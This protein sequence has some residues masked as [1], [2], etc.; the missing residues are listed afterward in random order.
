MGPILIMLR[1]SVTWISGPNMHASA[2][3]PD[4]K[5]QIIG[6][7]MHGYPS[8]CSNSLS[9]NNLKTKPD[10]LLIL[11]L[12]SHASMV[13]MLKWIHKLLVLKFKLRVLIWVQRME[14]RT[15]IMLATGPNMGANRLHGS[16]SL[17]IDFIAYSGPLKA[18]TEKYSHFALCSK[19]KHHLYAEIQ[20]SGSFASNI[21]KLSIF[22]CLKIL[23]LWV[24]SQNEATSW[25]GR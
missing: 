12:K 4:L 1:S 14:L 15:I 23:D 6:P 13:L 7:N 16:T 18:P 21:P 3:F 17:T 10:T 2:T 11:V 20:Y 22:T 9:Q 25:V 8:S 19:T 24:R 5:I